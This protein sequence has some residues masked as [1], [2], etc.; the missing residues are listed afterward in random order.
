MKF[1]GIRFKE[2]REYAGLTLGQAAAIVGWK[3]AEL[4][5]LER[6]ERHVGMTMLTLFSF[7]YD[8]NPDYLEGKVDLPYEISDA[9][10]LETIRRLRR[11]AINQIAEARRG[12]A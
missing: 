12:A 2:A 3:S 11:M 9:A 7:A 8:V 4:R 1:R 5:E 6:G 10:M